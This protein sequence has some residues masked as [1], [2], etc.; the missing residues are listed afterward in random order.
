MVLILWMQKHHRPKKKIPHNFFKY[1]QSSREL[2]FLVGHFCL[3]EI[4]FVDIFWFLR[5]WRSP[6]NTQKRSLLLMAT[7]NPAIIPT[8]DGGK[9][10]NSNDGIFPQLV[11]AGFLNHQQHESPQQRIFSFSKIPDRLFRKVK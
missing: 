7:R 8:W 2:F 6:K 11:N 10:T 4:L 1:P 5:T 3:T 9:K